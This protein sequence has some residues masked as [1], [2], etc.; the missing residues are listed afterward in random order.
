[1]KPDLYATKRGGAQRF[2]DDDYFAARPDAMYRLRVWTNVPGRKPWH[3]HIGITL[4]N[5]DTIRCDNF[6]IRGKLGRVGRGSPR[7]RFKAALRAI[8]SDVNFYRHA[9]A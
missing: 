3:F 4:R 2:R 6:D 5:G 7:E 1:M 9:A 8:I